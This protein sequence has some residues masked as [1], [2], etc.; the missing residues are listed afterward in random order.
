MGFVFVILVTRS[1]SAL[2]CNYNS[3]WLSHNFQME[4]CTN[5]AFLFFNSLSL[6]YHDGVC[7]RGG[8]VCFAGTRCVLELETT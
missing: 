1:F 4:K 7:Q 6:F 2:L 8:I 3:S 5:L